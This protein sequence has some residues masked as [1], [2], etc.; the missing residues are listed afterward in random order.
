MVAAEPD[1]IVWFRTF[2]LVLDPI[3]RTNRRGT[4][5]ALCRGT[6]KQYGVV[7]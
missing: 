5:V 4:R 7:I 2:L 3:P 1:N 6:K